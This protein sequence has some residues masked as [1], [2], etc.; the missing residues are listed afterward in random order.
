MRKYLLAL[1]VI[2]VI[3]F[4]GVFTSRK[5]NLNDSG[6]NIACTMDAKICPDGSSVGRSGPRC[7]FAQCPTTSPITKNNKGYL[8]GQ[9]TLSP[10]CP[11]E[12]VPPD[13]NCAPKGFSTILQVTSRNFSIQVHT[14]SEGAFRM[15]LLPGTYNLT[16][17]NGGRFPRCES[18]EAIV[19][20]NSTTTLDISC[21]SGIR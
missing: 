1:L 15:L 19:K 20:A 6:G 16:V 5:V 8:K 9:V 21:D 7:E 18:K 2:I 13:P 11:V 14:D 12:R 3:T 10:V 17:K 4:V